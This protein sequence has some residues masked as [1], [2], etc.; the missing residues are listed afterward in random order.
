[1]TLR[2]KETILKVSAG[3][4][5]PFSQLPDGT[6]PSGG[7]CEAATMFFRGSHFRC[8]VCALALWA[9]A[10]GVG[11][12]APAVAADPVALPAKPAEGELSSRQQ[13]LMRDYERFEK[14][15]FDVAEQARR[16]DP[17]RAD[18]LYRARSQSQEANVLAEMQAISELLRSGNPEQGGRRPQYGPA[19]DRQQELLA[20]MEGLLK[21]LQS[22]DERDRIASDIARLQELLKENGRLISR[23][24][25]VRAETQRG[26]P[27]DQLKQAQQKL[28]EDTGKLG[29][30][31]D[32]QDE[33]RRQDRAPE[34]DRESKQP[35]D[36]SDKTP[37]PKTGSDSKQ[38]ADQQP[39]DKSGKPEEQKSGEKP[40]KNQ[41]PSP[42]DSQG[43]P[44]PSSPMPGEPSEP[45]GQGEK[46]SPPQQQGKPQP[47]EQQKSQPPQDSQ[48]TPGREELEQARREMQQAI[49]EL[50]KEDRQKAAEEQDEAVAKLEQMKARLEEILRQLREDEKESY[51]T[52]LEARFQ[53]MLK[54]QLRV[55]SE[56]VRLDSIPAA[57][58]PQ[59]NYA[60]QT[61]NIRKEQDDNSLEAEK[62]LSLL[63]EEGSSVAFPEAVEQMHRN[64]R[65]VG[66]RLL[67]QDTGKTTQLVER[68]IVETLEEM[69][70]AL[71]KELE[72]N[73][74]QKQ[75]DKSQQQQQGQPDDP[76]LVGQLAELKLIRSLQSQVNRLSAEIG[77]E[78]EG[79]TAT[80]PAQ[81]E[82]LQDLV[83][84]QRRLKEATYDLSV[85][86]N[87]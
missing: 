81:I 27:A 58:R 85:G 16:K 40:A 1:M 32:R 67:S 47:G 15:L 4:S 6:T 23:Q 17:E 36:K 74:Q 53:N 38:G 49:D 22:L 63:K 52:L 78:I 24:K 80:D 33:E 65:V 12:S 50:E 46:K 29:E 70:T 54:R 20:R 39:S 62:T 79:K 87:K 19:V 14:S 69:I 5:I 35:D 82:L 34:N 60:S 77:T 2:T 26:K 61:D 3:D 55:N 43:H 41:S 10:L 51:L 30:K 64:M 31:I 71:R 48:R 42:S 66:S 75:N 21:L 18:L 83:R 73:E 8:S 28:A 59:Q 7:R 76:S 84:R 13:Q 72:K 44:S 57:D 56:T 37:E 68:L 25:E 45:Q 86:R 9:L 11:R